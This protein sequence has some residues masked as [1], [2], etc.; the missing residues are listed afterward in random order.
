[1]KEAIKKS[2]SALP[3]L[4]R[5]IQLHRINGKW[6]FCQFFSG[7]RALWGSTSDEGRQHLP[8]GAFFAHGIEHQGVQYQAMGNRSICHAG[9]GLVFR[10]EHDVDV[11]HLVKRRPADSLHIFHQHRMT[12][13]VLDRRIRADL[14]DDPAIFS[15]IARFFQQ[16]TQ[17][18]CRPAV[19]GGSPLLTAPPGISSSMRSV[20]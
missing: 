9:K 12:V 11:F 3:L 6:S 4:C 10:Y 8:G 7:K 13:I 16:L 15:G 19:R 18:R 5:L 1:M 14:A 2:G 17:A 20:P